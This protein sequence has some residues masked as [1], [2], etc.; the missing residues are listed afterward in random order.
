MGSPDFARDRKLIQDQAARWRI[1]AIYGDG[2]REGA[3]MTYGTNEEELDRQAATYVNRILRGANPGDLPIEQ[4]TKFKL[5]VN[6]KTAKAIG[7][8]MPQSLLLQVDE[9]I[10]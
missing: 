1:P 3:L 5:V 9:I 2:A 8:T 6:F 7:L 10:D 4:P